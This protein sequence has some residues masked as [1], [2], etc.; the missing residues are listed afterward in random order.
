MKE[1]FSPTDRNR[2]TTKISVPFSRIKFSEVDLQKLNNWYMYLYLDVHLLMQPECWTYN[3]HF[4][5]GIA[6]KILY[7]FISYVFKKYI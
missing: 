7:I 6:Y 5:I 4:Y 1:T 2:K 3:I